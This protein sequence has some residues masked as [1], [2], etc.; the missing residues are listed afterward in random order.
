MDRVDIVP[1]SEV[2]RLPRRGFDAHKGTYGT[3]QVVAGSRGMAGAAILTGR[4]ALRSGAGLV[5]VATPAAVQ[6]T[7]ALG[8]PACTTAGIRQHTDGSFGD[9][10]GE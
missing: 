3:V 5:R 10:A 7:V 6:E 8:C 2:P 1:V 4:A 9:G